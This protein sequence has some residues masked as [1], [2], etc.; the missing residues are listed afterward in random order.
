MKVAAYQ[1]RVAACYSP[2]AVHELSIHVRECERAGVSLLCC[3]E[4][5]LGGLADYVDEPA[6]IALSADPA[7]IVVKLRPLTSRTVTVIVGFTERDVSRAYYNAAAIC[8][9][10]AVLGTYRKRHPAIRRSRYAAGSEA[11]VF[12]VN[13]A[14]LGIL[15]CR[16]STD[17]Q[18]ARTLVERGAQ[19]LCVPT[20]NA[21]PSDRIGPQFVDG[22]R[23]L[24]AQ[25][26]ATLGVPVIRADVVGSVGSLMGPGT[27]AITPPSARQVCARGADA[28]ELIVAELSVRASR[29]P[30]VGISV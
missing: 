3:P 13:G 23:S 6:T 27:S 4:A 25:L 14:N 9:G 15:I 7:A 1:M 24:D 10:G 22:V 21:M 12:H 28:G 26:A 18:L 8:R 2:D 19:V 16:D 5:A 29:H 17:A 11:P 30:R 20:N